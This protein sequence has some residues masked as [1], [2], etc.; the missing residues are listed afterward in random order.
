M[1]CAAMRTLPDRRGHVQDEGRQGF[2]RPLVVDRIYGS[3]NIVGPVVLG[4]TL[5]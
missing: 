1:S 2:G 3:L 5:V 4:T